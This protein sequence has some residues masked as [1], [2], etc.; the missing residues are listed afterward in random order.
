ME[1]YRGNIV[2]CDIVLSAS[3]YQNSKTQISKRRDMKLN[4]IFRKAFF[5]TLFIK[6]NNWHKFSVLGHTF[7]LVVHATKANSIE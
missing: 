3:N 5:I 1:I 6:Q 2:Y 4:K 7:A